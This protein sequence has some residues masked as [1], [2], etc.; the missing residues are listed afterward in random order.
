MNRTFW[1]ELWYFLL[2][3]MAGFII[4]A[5]VT[6]GA[7]AIQADLLNSV[8][9]YHLIQWTQTLVVMVIPALLWCRWRLGEPISSGLRVSNCA[10]W[11]Q[12]LLVFALSLVSLPL[13]DILA[14]ACRS[15]PLPDALKAIADEESANQELILQ[16]M[17]SVNGFGGWFELIMLMSVATAIG[18]ELTF[19]GA[20]LALF[21]RYSSCNK[22]VVAVVIGLVFSIIHMEIYGLIPRWILGTAFVYLVYYTG[23]I[24]PAVLAH[25]INNLYALM[26]YKGVI[27]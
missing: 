18:E 1:T 19:R 6:A 7:T 2:L 12:Y 15:I 3:L 10:N 14:E 4:V 27:D 26:Q 23:C 8:W 5:I 20:L 9:Y 17:L 21:R 16:K 13:L 11:K 25:A 22:H 24:W